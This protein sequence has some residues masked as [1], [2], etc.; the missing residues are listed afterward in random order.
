M[1]LRTFILIAAVFT[2]STLMGQD[3]TCKDQE[4]GKIEF[5]KNSAKLTVIAKA[6][7]DSLIFVINSQLTC[8]VVATSYFADFCDKCGALSW[9]R[10]NTIISYLMKK[11]IAEKRLR[12]NTLGGNANIVILTFA[13]WPLPDSLAPHPNLRH[14]NSDD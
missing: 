11:G 4:L 7:L 8:E 10:Q 6:K 3:T 14:K 9:N 12:S 2:S 13:S 5:K 1:R